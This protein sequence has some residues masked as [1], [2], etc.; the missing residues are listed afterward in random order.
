MFRT[1]RAR[2]SR[3]VSTLALA[4][5][6]AS[7][8]YA[9][10][11][12][13]GQTLT[14]SGANT[15]PLVLDAVST[16]SLTLNGSASISGGS[17]GA[18]TIATALP[19]YSYYYNYLNL[20]VNGAIDGQGNAGVSVQNGTAAA[21]QY[22]GATQGAILVGA[23]G[24]ITGASGVT[25]SATPGNSL[26][27]AFASVDNAGSI[28]ATSGPALV[29]I[30]S[31][32]GGFT[33]IINRST[34][35]IGGISGYFGTISN[36]GTI[37]GGSGSAVRRAGYSSYLYDNGFTNS[38]TI[39]S[40]GSAS[41]ISLEGSY[42]STIDNSGTIV[43]GGS[44]LAISAAN[45]VQIN[46]RSAATI[47]TS[48]PT[49]IS[50]GSA[51]YLVSPGAIRGSIVAGY[52]PTYY[53]PSGSSIDIS[54][55]GTVTGNITLGAGDDIVIADFNTAASPVKGVT[56]S[57]DAGAGNDTLQLNFGSDST[58][59]SSITTPATFERLQFGVGNGAT[60]TLGS[61]FSAPSTITTV[62][63]AGG[64]SLINQADLSFAGK[65]IIQN[66]A[67]SSTFA[68][69][70][71][72][73]I[74]AT[75]TS[76]NDFAIQF[77][78][79]GGTLTNTGT[80]TAKVG[81]AIDTGA[82]GSLSNSGTITADGTAVQ[83]SYGSFTNSGTIRSNGGTGARITGSY[84]TSASNSGTIY[85]A[86][87]GVQLQFSTIV[88][89]GTIGSANLGVDLT[90][91]STLDNRAGGV[92]NGGVGGSTNS[93]VYSGRITNA[94]TIN[95]NVNLSNS[96]FPTYTTG[97]TFIAKTGG[98]VNGNLNLGTGNDLFVTNIVNNG[99]GQFAG[100]T[101]TVTGSGSETLRYLV[102]ADATATLSPAGIFGKIGYELSNNASLTLTSSSQ[103]N[104]AVDLAGSGKVD[105]TA[106]LALTG[107][108]SILNLNAQSAVST[109][110][111]IA[112]N[113]LDVTSHGT[114][115][116]IHSQLYSY[117]APAVVLSTGSSFTN[118]GTIIVRELAPNPYG[119]N[120]L[121]AIQGSGTVT[122][123]GTISVD[124]ATAVS[125]SDIYGPA[126]TFINS[127]TIN[128]VAGG[129][130]GL[131]VT[132][133]ASIT[134]SGSI[135]TGGAA[136]VLGSG[137][138]TATT[139]T[140]SGTIRSLNGSAITGPS[141]FSTPQGTIINL[142]GGVISGASNSAAIA[143]SPGLTLD[144]AGT[145][146]GNVNLAASPYSYYTPYGS[147]IYV[148]SGG[149]IN[150]NLTFGAGDDLFLSLSGA[151]GVTGTLDGGAGTDTFAQ[152]YSSSATVAADGAL[153]LNFERRGIGA[154]G[155]D[156]TLTVTGPAAGLSNGLFL[157]GDG[158][159]I[160]QANVKASLSSYAPSTITLGASS[161][162]AGTRSTLAFTNQAIVAGTITGSVRSFSNSGTIGSPNL[163]S[164]T[165][166]LSAIDA[167]GFEFQNSGNII[168]STQGYCS[169]YCGYGQ[170]VTINGQI[171]LVDQA[172][173]PLIKVATFDNSGIITGGLSATIN[174]SD[175]TLTNSGT[176]NSVSSIYSPLAVYLSVG[177]ISSYPAMPV[178]YTANSVTITN[179]GTAN[180]AIA[181][182]FRSRTT[183]FVNSGTIQ[184]ANAGAAVSLYVSA[185]QSYDP[186]S[187][188]FLDTDQDSVSFANSGS[189]TGSVNV[190][191]VAKTLT[192]NNSGTINLSYGTPGQFYVGPPVA[193]TLSL[194]STSDQ[195]I[196]LTNS[197]TI[198]NENAGYATVAVSSTAS[199]GTS[200]GMDGLPVAGGPTSNISIVNAGAIGSKA[201]GILYSYGTDGPN[202]LLPSSALSVTATSD[203][204]STVSIVNAAGGDIYTTAGPFIAP[205]GSYQTNLAAS[206]GTIA[207]SAAADTV[208]IRNDGSIRGGDGGALPLNV[209]SQ[210]GSGKE[211]YLAGAI[212]TFSST[213]TV[214][215]SKTGTITGSIDLGAFDDRL[216]NY[217]SISGNV[218]LRDGNDTLVQGIGATF[219]GTADGGDGT[220][221]L[222]VDITGGG[223]LNKAFY[224]RFVGFEANQIIGTGMIATD[225]PLPVD[226][227]RLMG[228]NLS[229]AAGSTLQTQGPIAITGDPLLANSVT[230]NG[231]I[232]GGILLG[233]G[234]DNVVNNG[235]ITG[236]VALGDGS[237]RFGGTGN[238]VGN[239]D[240]GAGSDHLDGALIGKVS[241]M[242]DGGSGTDSIDF[243]LAAA[244]PSGIAATLT[245]A[246]FDRLT[247]F[248]QVS[249]SGTGTIQASGALPV[250]SIQL[251]G[252]NLLVATG[253]SLG[254][255]GATTIV[256]SA[257]AEN[258]TNQGTITGNI[259]LGDGNDSLTTSG[260]MQGAVDLGAG[261]DRLI[262]TG[263]ATFAAA[264]T[265][266]GG[267]DVI[268]LSTSGTDTAPTQLNL[269]QTSAFETLQNSSGTNA[270]SGTL[271]VNQINI[272]GGRLIGKA[273]STISGAVAVA[274]GATFGSAGTVNGNISVAGTLSPG[275]SPGTMTIN[276]NVALAS[277]STTFFEMTPTV[278][279]AIVINGFLTVAT[280]S[281][282]AITGTR[283]LTPG[284]T[285]NLIT[286]SG[287]ISGT[288]TTVA[289]D[290]TVL[291]FVRQTSSA[292]QLLGTIQLPAGANP[293]VIRTTDYL[294]G[295]LIGGTA[296][297]GLIN[298]LPAL[299]S[300][301]GLGNPVAIGRLHPEA[302]A[303]ASQIGVENGLALAS[304]LRT[305]D[306]ASHQDDKGLFGFGQS[307][308]N[309]RNLPG[310]AA[311]GTSD[312][313]IRSAGIIGGIGYG[314]ASAA[315]G[316]FIGYSNA[317]QRSPAIGASTRADGLVLGL[318][319][320][321]R[322]DD[323]DLAATIMWDG[324]KADT[325]RALD[326]GATAFG[327]YH[328]RGWTIDATAGYNIRMANG[329]TLRPMA[330]LTHIDSRRS[331]TTESGAGI[332][333]LDVAARRTHATFVSGQIMLKGQP[334]ARFTPWLSAGVR[335]QFS[336][337]NSLA[338]A[339]L[340]GV[341]AT[342][343]VPG[344]ARNRTL[345]TAAGGLSA[346]LT[347][348]LDGFASASGEF[349]AAS[350]SANGTIGLRL[351]F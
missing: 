222:V 112:A 60:L 134:N 337:E 239:L 351:R 39:K 293:Q 1:N 98:V 199:N 232:V 301:T 333:N 161:G 123:S 90:L 325:R 317:H 158:A 17:P 187:Q 341:A 258:V 104:I 328:L 117:S 136:I 46:N 296:P 212:Q 331:G 192:V 217:G 306:L 349:G 347:A 329:W 214:V 271:A 244:N 124:G 203:G 176:I 44:G 36:G 297:V 178:D 291:G 83:F 241:G 211:T 81:G 115:T 281:T 298:G 155:Q 235:T 107:D 231:T 13:Q 163:T 19:P 142:A 307:F 344:V 42:V 29:A 129:S 294:N 273:G 87:V 47:A 175:V 233:A 22:Y 147:S 285:Y 48:G 169:Y 201:G 327:R 146:N 74:S 265:G 225:G 221:T 38:G 335:H 229:I 348:R 197:G 168:S 319:G 302:Y 166:S 216:E 10:C 73:S 55:G 6:L 110:Y 116:Q 189:I 77:L 131:G 132:N 164:T 213:D 263:A 259:A 304:A 186:A 243:T 140:N 66:Y 332:F 246:S 182:G 45:Q 185:H 9:S 290:T 282:L 209:S 143:V 106:N 12:R 57:I 96:F 92:I 245:A 314:S 153:P 254:T 52:A 240:L 32:V 149:T 162:P 252:T 51:L 11:D 305:T 200:R 250:D 148:N 88:N 184:V 181:G 274:S 237:D 141:S 105:L 65:A 183:T 93:F 257:M 71:S 170:A 279:D 70:N 165:V 227:L 37:D 50:V 79:S 326:S 224:D 40:S 69:T 284:I 251:T 180:G 127:G 23:G 76:P 343:T 8:A 59:S 159:I 172:A 269:S 120:P 275:A 207:L 101:G 85:G 109:T 144:N 283:P 179:S 91:G 58:L 34:G 28:T 35:L 242:I 311:A 119:G 43:N 190:N 262:I 234:D 103:Q 288:F 108:R 287:G 270:L 280:G 215:N 95:G 230:N 236:D 218:F 177:Q 194:Q 31:A 313:D 309:L 82:Q 156:V 75:L 99:P 340:T 80:I 160:N 130:D 318:L 167:D 208:T 310:N 4:A 266:G 94:G 121:V 63:T 295:L 330:G 100:V 128:Q 154:I 27:Y 20:T 238:V 53:P 264:V 151:T 174:A 138:P 30:D 24:S 25:V 111:P 56:G 198:T 204:K 62:A 26:A 334:D 7:P 342:F 89:T 21:Y 338:T 289:K 41:T 171:T 3:N 261:D 145:I 315:L 2:I 206:I 64:G 78:G 18:V 345:A 286:A 139:I 268:Q 303:S 248:E 202:Y 247:N 150:G 226:S 292:I 68:I 308:G 54:G 49:A 321:A 249:V 61:G 256:G 350:S 278:S 223:M 133:V 137:Y 339:S 255:T 5:I 152:G 191:G 113:A 102:E 16:S 188:N 336:G 210:I 205:Y 196:S 260:T 277:G 316:G 33:S 346:R 195:T 72:G 299:L 219:A 84:G 220:D 193:A 312:A 300:P 122:N 15:G 86:S 157:F 97:N 253:T 323:L 173:S 267:N 14:C 125:G 272:N 118:A 228:G 320:Q 324:G 67:Y 322:V 276:G 135:V 114:L 126:L